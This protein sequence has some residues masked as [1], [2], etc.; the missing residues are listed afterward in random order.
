[1]EKKREIELLI[2]CLQISSQKTKQ[3]VH[4][5][6]QSESHLPTE[7]LGSFN[8]CTTDRFSS[9]AFKKET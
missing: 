7:M 2:K 3:Q 5:P 6:S 4:Q 8:P 1:M 9:F